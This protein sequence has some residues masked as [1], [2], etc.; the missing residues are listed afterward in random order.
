[1]GSHNLWLDINI[2]LGS[3]FQWFSSWLGKK[4]EARRQK[5]QHISGK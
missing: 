5:L 3:R 1:M 4:A 2:S